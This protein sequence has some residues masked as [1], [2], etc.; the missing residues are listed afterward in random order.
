M[1]EFCD[2]E[3]VQNLLTRFPLMLEYRDEK[4]V[5]VFRRLLERSLKYGYW[6]GSMAA[7][8]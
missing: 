7:V 3:R 5:L 8:S 6:N 2:N 4:H 1:N